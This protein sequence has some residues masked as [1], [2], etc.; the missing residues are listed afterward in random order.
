[1]ASP[2]IDVEAPVLVPPPA[3]SYTLAPGVDPLTAGQQSALDACLSAL[4]GRIGGAVVTA[5][6]TTTT[7]HVLELMTP[8]GTLL[9]LE[10]ADSP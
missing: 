7:H 9:V 6:T 3:P 5:A 10:R 4:T 2:C 8:C 1:M